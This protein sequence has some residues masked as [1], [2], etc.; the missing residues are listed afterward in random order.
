[1]NQVVEVARNLSSEG[2]YHE[3]HPFLHHLHLHD[4]VWWNCIRSGRTACIRCTCLLGA[5]LP[6]GPS[7]SLLSALVPSWSSSWVL[8]FAFFWRSCSSRSWFC[9]VRRS[10]AA[11]RVWTYLSRAMV[12]GLSPWM[13]LVVA[14]EWVNTMQLFVWEAIVCL[15]SSFPQTAPTDDAENRQW[16]TQSSHARTTPALHRKKKT[17]REYQCGTS[18]IPFESQVR[19]L[20]ITL[21]CQSWVNYVYLDLWGFYSS[22]KLTLFSWPRRCFLMGEDPHKYTYFVR[23]FPYRDFVD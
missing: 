18:Q 10:T 7:W 1:M 16:V 8:S 2:V 9:L 5:L 22:V 19:E 14:I 20:F 12:H 4:H 21:E 11:V 15:T 6:S 23:F 3:V 17:S 13:L